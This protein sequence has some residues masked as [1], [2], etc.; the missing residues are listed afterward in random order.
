MSIKMY[1]QVHLK[2]KKK[3]Q[4]NNL[5]N[6]TVEEEGLGIWIKRVQLVNEHRIINT[7]V[8]LSKDAGIQS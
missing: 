6:K 1:L 8:Y 3:F 7:E 2:L 4:I 5:K